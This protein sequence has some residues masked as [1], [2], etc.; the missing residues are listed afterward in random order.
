MT[1]EV[2]QFNTRRLAF[3]VWQERHR[4]PWAAMNADPE[5]RRFFV[6]VLDEAQSSASMEAWRLQ[7]EQQGWSNWAIELIASGEFIGFIG[8]SR[9]RGPLPFGPCVEIGWRLKRQAWGNGYATEG[10]RECLRIGFERLELDRIVSFTA[11]T[12]LPSIAVMQR[13]GMHDAQADFDHPNVPAGHALSRHC[14]YT[15][16]RPEWKSPGG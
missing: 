7:F 12:N 6:S 3:R 15:I 13:I 16:A 4:A 14:L 8:L 1:V 5:V 9:P 11:L 2:L 10:A